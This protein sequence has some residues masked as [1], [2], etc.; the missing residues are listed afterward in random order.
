[1]SNVHTPASVENFKGYFARLPEWEPRH[2]TAL[3]LGYDPN[4]FTADK[5][6]SLKRKDPTLYKKYT[7]VYSIIEGH[8]S[9][10]LPVHTYRLVKTVSPL[11]FVNWEQNMQLGFPE[12]LR[13]MVYQFHR[14]PNYKDLSEKLKEEKDQLKKELSNLQQKLDTVPSIEEDPR[15]IKSLEIMVGAMARGKYSYDS[16]Y[17]RSNAPK[18]I[19]AEI[20]LQ[21]QRL[22]EDTVRKYLQSSNEHF[23]K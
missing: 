16:T 4:G 22:S 23:L 3:T 17:Q 11:D 19:A 1:M 10:H 18:A 5:L 21:G 6:S 13:E 8:I 12:D 9:L 7:N 20:T 15:K 2:A 14:V